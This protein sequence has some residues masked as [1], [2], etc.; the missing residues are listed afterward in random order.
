MN[1]RV[2]YPVRARAARPDATKLL[3]CVESCRQCEVQGSSRN[4]RLRHSRSHSQAVWES[5]ASLLGCWH[6]TA[7]ICCCAPCSGAVAAARRRPPSISIS[8]PQGAQQQSRWP[9][10][11]LSDRRTGTRT[12]AP[13]TIRAVPIIEDEF[14][15]QSTNIISAV[16]VFG[17]FIL[18]SI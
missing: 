5:S 14:G 17:R 11:L 9:L 6:D 12:D 7:R 10:L 18:R 1:H 8:C 16:L 2:Y 4:C 13:P 15:M 3:R